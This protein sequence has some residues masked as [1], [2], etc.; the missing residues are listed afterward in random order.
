[1]DV[2][3]PDFDYLIVGS[4]FGG[5]VSALR[6]AEKGWRVVVIEQ[7]RE[8]GPAEILEGK[9]SLRKLM[10]NPALGWRGYFVQHFFKH[11]SIIGGI[12]VGGGSIVWGAVMLEPKEAFYKAEALRKLGLDLRS[13]LAPHFVTAKRML[14]VTTNP[15]MTQ[16]DAY[17]EQ[18]SERMGKRSTFGPTPN[19]IFFGEPGKSMPDPFFGGEGPDRKGCH[20]CGGCLTGCDTGSKNSLYQNYLYLARRKGVQV[21]PDSK[22]DRINRLDDGMFQ[23]SLVSPMNGKAIRQI[24]AAKV[25]VSAGVVGTLELLFKNRD[26][27]RTLPEVSHTLGDEVRTNS[28]AITAS[29]H[30][31]GHD[32]TDGTSISSHFYPDAGTHATQNRFDRGYRFMR[33]MM[34]PLIDDDN[35]ARRA[36]RT[37]LGILKR[38]Q[39]LFR[40]IFAKDWE[41][42]ISIF[43]VMQDTDSAVRMRLQR[44]KWPRKAVKLKTE[45]INGKAAPSYIKMANQITREFAEITGGEPMN[46][47]PE[48][49][50]NASTT[51][52][53]LSGCSMGVSQ[54]DSVIGSNHEVHGIKGLF[55]VDGSS[56]P[57]NLGVNPSLTIT[58]MAE[59]FAAL[60]PMAGERR[61][62]QGIVGSSE[63]AANQADA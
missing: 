5:S 17:L 21:I 9:R 49:I 20:F 58:A 32:M 19:A 6:L 61:H 36:R 25:V 26:V 62:S 15:R 10:W 37:I 2:N 14:G 51:A 3:R 33:F 42:R 55:I 13:E 44:A 16:Q 35:P 53:I 52:H 54:A 8:I 60:Q 29:L 45:A 56:V 38:P 18:T 22:A 34:G 4:G 50:G 41:K 48:S 63:V 47:M 1:M 24:T 43:T 12:G 57:G 40:N 23:I 28:E 31:P 27:Y 39:L 59:R 7:G 30:P 11:I 46:L